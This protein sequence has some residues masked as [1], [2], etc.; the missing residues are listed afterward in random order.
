MPQWS[1]QLSDLLQ[2]PLVNGSL[3]KDVALSNGTTAVNHKLG[4][5]LQGWIITRVNGAATIY[6]SQTTN[7]TPNLTLLLVS[8]AAV[9]VSLYVF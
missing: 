8:N 5:A 6:D 7:N 4:R 1:T 2:N 9:T 3:L